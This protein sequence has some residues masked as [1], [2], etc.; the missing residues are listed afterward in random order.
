MF[1][2]PCPSGFEPCTS[3]S[4]R[5]LRK[6]KKQ[7]SVTHNF[8]KRPTG[9]WR[10]AAGGWWQLA[11]VGGWWLVVGGGWQLSVAKKKFGSSRTALISDVHCMTAELRVLSQ[12]REGSTARTF[13]DQAVLD[14]A[15]VSIRTGVVAA[16]Q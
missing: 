2:T 7:V 5:A 15:P 13:L 14:C 9:W 8:P 12:E 10:L 11:A 3:I 1:V 6:E 4:D 16:N